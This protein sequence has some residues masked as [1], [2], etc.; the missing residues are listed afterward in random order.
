MSSASRNFRHQLCGLKP[1]GRKDQ[2]ITANWGFSFYRYIV[3]LWCCRGTLPNTH[4]NAVDVRHTQAAL[5]CAYRMPFG[6]GNKCGCCQKTVY[7][8]EEVQCEGKSWHKSCFLCSEYLTSVNL[9]YVPSGSDQI[10]SSECAGMECRVF[11][12]TREKKL[13]IHRFEFWH[14]SPYLDPVEMCDRGLVFLL[15][16]RKVLTLPLKHRVF[17]W[18]S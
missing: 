8:A 2:C 18:R 5:L 11:G 6:G 9:L 3:V 15:W 7:F 14:P 4:L 16:Q 17:I 10:N 1:E 13:S 12:I